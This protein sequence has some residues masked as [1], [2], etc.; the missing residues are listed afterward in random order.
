MKYRNKLG[1]I[2]KAASLLQEPKETSSSVHHS[3]FSMGLYLWGKKSAILRTPY[4]G[5]KLKLEY[6][7][8]H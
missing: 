4:R 8:E 5:E 6:T 2:S 7:L 3:P 1:N